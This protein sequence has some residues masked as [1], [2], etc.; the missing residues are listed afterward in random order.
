MVDITEIYVHWY[1]GRSKSA[2]AASLGVDRKTVR[3]YLAPAEA[4]GITL[5]GPPMTETDWAGLIEGGGPLTDLIF[6]GLECATRRAL[7]V[8]ERFSVLGKHMPAW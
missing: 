6:R 4:S 2:L 5:G 1:A 8:R 7:P 3:K